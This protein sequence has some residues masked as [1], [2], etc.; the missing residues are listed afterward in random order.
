M[1]NIETTLHFVATLG[2]EGVDEL[3]TLLEEDI[4]NGCASGELA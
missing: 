1:G 4:G 2:N 3:M